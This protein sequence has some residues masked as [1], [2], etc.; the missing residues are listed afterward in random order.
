MLVVAP[1]FFY[2]L[3]LPGLR[4]LLLLLQRFGLARDVDRERSVY[5]ALVPAGAAGLIISLLDFNETPVGATI[6]LVLA[7]LCLPLVAA[8]LPPL[9]SASA[10]MRRLERRL[11][12]WAHAA[13]AP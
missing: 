4:W 2:A 7:M 1:F 13:G 10:T 12:A 6:G 11:R 5:P 3:L 9:L 8:T